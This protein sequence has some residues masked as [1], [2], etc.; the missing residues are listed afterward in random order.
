MTGYFSQ[1]NLFYQ[2]KVA[3]CLC[4]SYHTAKHKNLKAHTGPFI[5]S[6]DTSVRPHRGYWFLNPF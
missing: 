3:K 6:Y 1:H 4:G 2:N 5:A